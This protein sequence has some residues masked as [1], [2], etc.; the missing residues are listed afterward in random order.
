MLFSELT[1]IQKAMESTHNC[2]ATYVKSALVI[3]VFQG[4]VG[5]NGMVDIFELSGHAKAKRCYGWQY[6][7]GDDMRTATVLEI[8]P[9]DSPE[10]AVKVAISA[11]ARKKP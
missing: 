7:E 9:V 1:A 6:R 2:D 8:P 3:D 4:Q 10:I 5:W 11:A